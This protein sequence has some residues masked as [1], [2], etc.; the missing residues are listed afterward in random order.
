MHEINHSNSFLHQALIYFS[1]RD[2][3]IHNMINYYCKVGANYAWSVIKTVL[4][5]KVILFISYSPVSRFAAI[6]RQ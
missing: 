5:L 2:Q 4:W 1:F 6:I 3:I